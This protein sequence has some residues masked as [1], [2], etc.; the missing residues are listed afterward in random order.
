M[1]FGIGLKKVCVDPQIIQC[2]ATLGPREQTFS[3][4]PLDPWFQSVCHPV[5]PSW[6]S[7]ASAGDVG[8]L[9]VWSAVH[10]TCLPLHTS[11]LVQQKYQS[12]GLQHHILFCFLFF[13]KTLCISDKLKYCTE[14]VF[15]PLNQ[16][17][18]FTASEPSWGWFGNIQPFFPAHPVK[19]FSGLS[20][21]V[22]MVW[23]QASHLSHRGQSGPSAPLDLIFL[24]F[25]CQPLGPSEV[26]SAL[27]QVFIQFN[28]VLSYIQL[29]LHPPPAAE[30]TPQTQCSEYG[31][32][33]FL[34]L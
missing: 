31:Q 13:K 29:S 2:E 32:M 16:K 8:H 11:V 19:P 27:N 28:S 7:E 9:Q 30:R 17:H 33:G 22:G 12:G 18:L 26:L 3:L 20:T 21:D 34:M 6:P 23:T 15:W 25:N 10:P 4:R 14:K 1:V 24:F 5:T